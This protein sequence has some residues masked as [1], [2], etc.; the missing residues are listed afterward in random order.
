MKV[1]VVC[2]IV[3]CTVMVDG[4]TGPSPA[5]KADEK[6]P[7][8]GLYQRQAATRPHE[9]K[10]DFFTAST[11]LVNK[12]DLDYGA[13]IERRRQAF[14]D[15]S[16]A[17]PFFWYSALTTGLL[18]VLMLAY[19]VRVMDEKRK[20][21]RAAEI[22]NDVWNDAQYAR[23]LAETAIQKYNKHMEECNRVIEAQL[24]GR[25]SP[26][27][28]E[29][30]DAR[31]ELTRLRGELDTVDSERKVLKAKLDDKERLIDELSA[32]LDAL[33]K[34]GQTGGSIQPR[35]GSGT[36][37]PN[38]TERKLIARINQLTEQLEAEKQKNRTLKGA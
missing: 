36:P 23:A 27:A 33:E 32:R 7:A 9:Q 16:A 38:E 30:T 3:A 35:N 2:M 26:T 37:G 13:M 24:S 15:A 29:A 10:D 12:N 34:A 20:L 5:H 1:Q 19:G 31:N 21:W 14:L 25:A 4:Q 11:K 17:N 8:T 18:M 22:L 28:L 6:Q